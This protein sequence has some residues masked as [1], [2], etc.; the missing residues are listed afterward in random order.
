MG[1]TTDEREWLA[2]RW[3]AWPTEFEFLTPSEWAEQNRY[4]PASV[5]PFPGPFSFD[6]APYIRE[7]LDCLSPESP[8]RELAFMKGSQL[9]ITVGV[10][11]NAIGYL[12]GYVKH[13]PVAM[14]TADSDMAKLRMESYI[15][16]MIE[17]SGLRSRIRSSDPNNKRKTGDTDKKMEW[18]G[19]GFLLPMGARNEGKMRSF[20]VQYLLDDEIDGWPDIAGKE[21]DP[22]A[23]VRKRVGGYEPT[24]KILDISTPTIQGQSKI[25]AQFK[26]G[27]QRYYFVRCLRCE[28]EQTLRFERNNPET[29]ERTGLT[30]ETEND[31]LVAASVRYLCQECSHPH[32]DAD[33]TRMLSP[34]HG[35][36]WKPTAVP[37]SP[38]VRS[39]HLSALYSPP[40]MRSWASLVQEW[41]EAYD[42]RTGETLDY[43]KLQV[44]YNTGLGE[45]FEIRGRGVKFEE[46]SPHR[47]S[48]YKYGE[49][50]NKW[51]RE[52]CGGPVLLLTC[53]V[54]VHKD[55]L[56]VAVHGWCRD[57]R[58]L[59]ID[60]HTLEGDTEQI[61][62][63]A[64][65]GAL[66][67]IL[68][69][70]EYTADDD[71]RYHMEDSLAL[72]DSGYSTDIVYRFCQ[73]FSEGVYP[74]KGVSAPPKSARVPEFS[75]FKTPNGLP[76]Y[77]LT[78]DLY[79]DRWAAA[80]RREWDGQGLMPI[81]H[82]S[83]PTDATDKQ[84]KELTAEIKTK[85]L[86][87]GT[88]KQ[89]GWE[90]RRPGNRPNELWDLLIYANGA[91][92]LLAHAYS[93]ELELDYTN[94]PAFW[95]ACEN[96]QRYYRQ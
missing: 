59:L 14:V 54:D 39:Y 4:L 68:N 91:L 16:P 13:A 69:S 44:F 25:E 28:F 8:V 90:W 30:W 20:S 22:V 52:H 67:D 55:N 96:E 89:I 58:P 37:V 71:R 46:V 85:K 60:Y 35:A 38:D 82:F 64:T 81:G 75:S 32:T 95:D 76:A 6:V 88:K 61:D 9:C 57:R 2:K 63:P 7:P 12:I 19:G 72:I 3:E 21:G 15:R 5:T 86:E 45:T 43:E 73:E 1:P 42:P 62:N 48:V 34:D 74:I 47:R 84:L 92:D 80:L 18:I 79:K 70:R 93:Q 94:W 17:H 65:W 56:K 83:A 66:R 78:V 31:R 29:G 51:A 49:I 36:R 33:K 24:R 11:E 50:P 41:L 87:R 23:I 40:G 26:R 10:L 53:T 27:D 77:G